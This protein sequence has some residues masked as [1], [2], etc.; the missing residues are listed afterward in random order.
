[1]QNHSNYIKLNKNKWSYDQDGPEKDWVAVSAKWMWIKVSF[2]FV[3]WSK[4][5]SKKNILHWN[6]LVFNENLHHRVIYKIQ[7]CTTGTMPYT[8]ALCAYDTYAWSSPV[9]FCSAG[10]RVWFE[11]QQVRGGLWAARHTQ[12]EDKAYTYC[13]QPQ[14]SHNSSRRWQVRKIFLQAQA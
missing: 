5:N 9:T 7:R 13:F 3:F 14:T 1:M 11:C 2:C 6:T 10:P 4:N 8:Y 12:K